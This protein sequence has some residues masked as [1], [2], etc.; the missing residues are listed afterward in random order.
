MPEIK[1]DLQWLTLRLEAAFFLLQALF[2][3]RVKPWSGLREQ[4]RSLPGQQDPELMRK[5]GGAVHSVEH[6]VPLS[7]ICVPV[8]MATRSMCKRRGMQCTVVWEAPRHLSQVGHVSVAETASD[9][10]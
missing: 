10:R 6:H 8:V 9:G 2:L 7:G 4:L 5:I 1:R 3:V